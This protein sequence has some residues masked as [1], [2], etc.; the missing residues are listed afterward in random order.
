[1]SLKDFILMEKLGQGS[2]ATVCKALRQTDQKHYAIKQVSASLIKIKI[3]RL[4]EKSKQN[5]LN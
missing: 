2:Y 1:M 5:A 3:N 4:D